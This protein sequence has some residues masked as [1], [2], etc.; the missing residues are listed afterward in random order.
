MYLICIF[1]WFKLKYIYIFG[2]SE[3]NFLINYCIISFNY[4]KIL[5]IIFSKNEWLHY[6]IQSYETFTCSKLFK[7][8]HKNF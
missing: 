6:L 8:I 4:W 1:G 5:E 7:Y 2:A 3:M